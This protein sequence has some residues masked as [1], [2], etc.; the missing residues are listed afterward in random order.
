MGRIENAISEYD[1]F[2]VKNI[3][4]FYPRDLLEL[5]NLSNNDKCELI[6]KSLSAGF[7]IGYRAGM[8]QAKKKERKQNEWTTGD[9]RKMRFDKG[10]S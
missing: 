10:T 2:C 4:L 9:N 1:K 5:W 3:G 8:R 7:V 6:L